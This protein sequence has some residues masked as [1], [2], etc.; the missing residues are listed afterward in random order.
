MRG[1]Q[2]PKNKTP[3][4]LSVPQ[5]NQWTDEKDYE[6]HPLSERLPLMKEGEDFEQ[7]ADDIAANGQ[8]E[9]VKIYERKILDGRN[10]YRA[11]KARGIPCRFEKLTVDGDPFDYVLSLNLH[12]IFCHRTSQGRQKRP[13]DCRNLVHQLRNGSSGHRG[14]N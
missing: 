10:R 3:E 7:F 5:E 4:N 11:C 8:K 13:P 2:K 1:K 9:T 14:C 12:T 6:F